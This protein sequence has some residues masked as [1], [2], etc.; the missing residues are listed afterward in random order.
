LREFPESSWKEDKPLNYIT[1]KESYTIDVALLKLQVLCQR[2]IFLDDLVALTTQKTVHRLNQRGSL[3]LDL[4][5]N[6]S[7]SGLN[8]RSLEDISFVN[9]EANELTIFA[10]SGVKTIAGRPE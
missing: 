8:L 5:A 1:S 2:T 3:R 6:L 10:M 7:T 4:T 9:I